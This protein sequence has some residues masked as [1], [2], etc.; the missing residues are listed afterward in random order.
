MSDMKQFV[1]LGQTTSALLAALLLLGS[2]MPAFRPDGPPPDAP[3]RLRSGLPFKHSDTVLT[4]HFVRSLRDN[5]GLLCLGT[6]ETTTLAGGNWPDFLNADTARAAVLAGAGR[7]PGVHLPWLEAVSGELAGLGLVYYLNPVY[8]NAALGPV[9]PAYFLRYTT[10][11]QLR[12]AAQHHPALAEAHAALPLADRLHPS[13][14][15]RAIRRPWFQDFRWRFLNPS[16]FDD[17]FASL[18]TF[19]GSPPLGPSPDIDLEKGMLHSFAHADWFSPALPPGEASFRD[20][21]LR[22]FIA[23]CERWEVDLTI[24]LGPPNLSFIR[25]HAPE[26]ELASHALQT[27]LR[28]LLGNS[29]VHFVDASDLGDRPGVFNDHQHISSYGASLIA[30]RLRESL[31]LPPLEP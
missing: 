10:P 17:A 19:A 7:T 27:H 24:I 28:T 13:P 25:H 30:G 22:A 3:L 4:A 14:W 15:L 29:G 20:A 9:D 2:L 12:T 21:E 1:R 31:N 26:A 11:Q 8:W 23:A 6:S 18:A 5:G 16:G